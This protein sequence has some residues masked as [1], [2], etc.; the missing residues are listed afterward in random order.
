MI[1]LDI[2]MDNFSLLVCIHYFQETAYNSYHNAPYLRANSSITSHSA[3]SAYSSCAVPS[4]PPFG[5][6]TTTEATGVY[7]SV[8]ALSALE[9]T[10]A[11]S[12]SL[13]GT[14]ALENDANTSFINLSTPLASSSRL[15]QINDLLQHNRNAT[16]ALVA[17]SQNTDGTDSRSAPT[18]SPTQA[19]GSNSQAETSSACS[20]TNMPHTEDDRKS[21][22]SYADIELPFKSA[23]S[24]E[25][26]ESE[27]V[28]LLQLPEKDV[29]LIE[30]VKD[31]TL[32][33][34]SDTRI[35]PQTSSDNDKE[36]TIMAVT[37]S[38]E[39]SIDVAADT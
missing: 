29:S 23:Q 7:H 11:P 19:G 20:M 31:T 3:S 30:H 24:K 4:I 33:I 27:S 25:Y 16:T 21:C 36:P 18:P 2:S 34:N 5:T 39:L 38:A 26:Q 15:S 12:C 1:G 8:N 10:T 37:A 14:T 13:N 35:L 17:V 28:E 9:T 22:M 6:A 32:L